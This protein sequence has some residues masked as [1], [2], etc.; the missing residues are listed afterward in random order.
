MDAWNDFVHWLG[1]VLSGAAVV[2]AFV[3]L[4]PPIAALVGV[5]YYSIQIYESQTVQQ[6]KATRRSRKIARLRKEIDR[7]DTASKIAI[8]KKVADAATASTVE[9]LTKSNSAP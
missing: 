5:V 3:G 1:H 6:W 4:L 9:T 7:L 8:V 2:G